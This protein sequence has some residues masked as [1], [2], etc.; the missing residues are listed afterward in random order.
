MQNK[1][2][3][4]GKIKKNLKHIKIDS[5]LL[6]LIF[7]SI[8]VTC[9]SFACRAS[10]AFNP[11]E[12]V[13]SVPDIFAEDFFGP[14]TEIT[15]DNNDN[16]YI[17]DF[18]NNR[19]VKF[20]SDGTFLDQWGEYGSGEGEFNYPD[21][22]VTDSSGNIYVSDLENDRIQKFDSSGSFIS[23]WGSSGNGDGEFGQI[24]GIAEDSDGNIYVSDL[25]NNKIQKFD[26][27]G[28]FIDSWGEY[29]AGNGDFDQPRN[30]FI[31]GENVYVADYANNR[32]QKFD[33]EGSYISS[34]GSA[35]SGDGEF[36]GP[37]WI[38]VDAEGNLYVSN[39]TDVRIQKFDSSGN[40]VD[41]WNSGSSP[42]GIAVDSDSNI[43]VTDSQDLIIRKYESN[44]DFLE[45][46]KTWGGENGQFNG[47][48]G[49]E[50][51]SENNIFV[52]DSGNNRIQKFDSDGNFVS[53]F[54]TEGTEDG[55][56]RHPWDIIIDGD[57]NLY[58]FDTNNSRIQKFDSD[59]NFL[60]KWGSAGSGDGQFEGAVY[61]M[62]LGFDGNIYVGDAPNSRIQ[63][64]DCDGNF[65][66]KIEFEDGSEEGQISGIG[67]IAVDPVGNI[68]VSDIDNARVQK[69]DQEGNFLLKWGVIGS[70]DGQFGQPR[71]IYVDNDGYVYVTDDD[72]S[73]IQ[74][75]DQ[76][77]NYL[78]KWGNGEEGGTENYMQ[79]PY[80]I[81]I[82]SDGAYAYVTDQG[83]NRLKIFN[84]NQQNEEDN[85][86]ENSLPKPEI[87]DIK[88]ITKDSIKFE[89][90]VDS[91]YASQ[92][93]DFEIKLKNKDEDNT[94]IKD[95]TGSVDE[96]GKITL[97]VDD[98]DP[99]TDYNISV[100]FSLKDQNNY[101]EYSDTEKIQ[102][103]RDIK[104]D[105]KCQIGSF[106]G[107]KTVQGVSLSWKKICSEIN[108][109]LIERKINNGGFRQ[110]TSLDDNETSYEDKMMLVEGEYVY[111]IRGY[112]GNGYTDYSEE[113]SV[114][115]FQSISDDETSG[116]FNK[117]QG[118]YNQGETKLESRVDNGTGKE[119][120]DISSNNYPGSVNN[121]DGKSGILAVLRN[122]ME[123]FKKELATVAFVGLA[124]G[125]AVAASPT[126]IPF[127]PSSPNPIGQRIFAI[128][129]ML[130]NRKKEQTDWG[131]VFDHETKMPI[132]GA[133]VSL[134]NELG[135]VVDTVVSDSQGRYGF[136][137]NSGSY[138]IQVHK[139]D[140]SLVGDK[141]VDSLYGDVY[142]GQ[143][144]NL[145]QN[146]I[147]KI[148]ISLRNDKV[149][150]RDFAER[151]IASLDSLFSVIKRDFSII[152][153]YGGF[154]ISF[155]VSL[156]F[157]G[158]IN[159]IVLFIYIFLTIFQLF[160]RKKSFGTINHAQ[161]GKPVPFAI[162][163]LYGEDNP[164]RRIKFA[165]TDV[166]GRYYLLAD[167]GRYLAK[168]SGNLLEGDRFEKNIHV[169]IEEGILRM[170]AEV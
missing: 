18:E 99:G 29:G 14:I 89:I 155:G 84:F 159:T 162:V 9:F 16:I 116:A 154:V 22:I 157:P 34:I 106:S 67:G 77:G 158:V 109:I 24:S 15:I 118:E 144:L 152:L 129:G 82:S 7:F 72:L 23:T 78:T 31:S 119:S 90:Q 83:T 146:Q 163:A 112:A 125:I 148:N 113:V 74:V 65:I 43:Y 138:V 167:N 126:G 2:F 5:I 21:D 98:L 76:N 95:R 32:V 96:N 87:K 128:I 156:M 164:E 37:T 135:H 6:A 88:E 75:F 134:I 26:S 147:E 142:V 81:A 17:S 27:D 151:K 20:N 68:Y 3:V 10:L 55:Q 47:P 114:K 143:K 91:S 133:I 110:I 46:W 70:G 38:C 166:L 35:G 49:V 79:T 131:V 169:N 33:L 41:S 160:M 52:V 94:D 40:F 57:D 122:Y 28:N 121:K 8:F 105:D 115:I 97:A 127:L 132:G 120:S 58:V 45:N 36:F 59:G 62:D 107:K 168:I 85:D 50:T 108:G 64:F 93:L 1:F 13:K 80:G 123:K 100:R 30:I 165:V 103:Q 130:S 71:D 25:E 73:R 153:F 48:I 170:D 141:N 4:M 44:G 12:F 149:D 117:L 42:R 102:T 86:E 63:I 145:A 104:N 137:P 56:F 66:S 60:A 161:T 19:V 150:W 136:L 54:G 140:Y 111:R 124:A 101:S 11:P 61:G 53:K 92:E 39:D 69:F 139:A 51:D